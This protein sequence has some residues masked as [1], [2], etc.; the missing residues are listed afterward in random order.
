MKKMIKPLTTPAGESDD[1]GNDELTA[2]ERPSFADS[3][4]SNALDLTRVLKD[5]EGDARAMLNDILS[6]DN[7]YSEK[8]RVSFDEEEDDLLNDEWDTEFVERLLQELDE[9]ELWLD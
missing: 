5:L 3:N 1:M 6:E 8:V 9:D 2:L 7:E 4:D